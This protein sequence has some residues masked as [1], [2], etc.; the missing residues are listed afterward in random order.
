[1][2]KSP[3]KIQFY[4]K[5]FI[6]IFIIS[7]ILTFI[8]QLTNERLNIL[9]RTE[10]LGFFTTVLMYVFTGM[11][12]GWLQDIYILIEL[13][14][15][16]KCTINIFPQIKDF[17]K[18]NLK[19][20]GNSSLWMFLLFI[21]GLIR[22]IDYSLIGFIVFLNPIYQAGE[23]DPLIYARILVKNHKFKFRL[24]WIFIHL[25]IPII[26]AIILPGS[27]LFFENPIKAISLQVFNSLIYVIWIHILWKFF[28]LPI[29]SNSLQN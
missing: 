25:I 8:E 6:F 10:S 15:T 12:F 17:V 28:R 16:E 7:S 23:I 9:A 18:E 1:M 5:I 21:P 29:L 13:A 14:K 19:A 4:L 24:A 11:I 26:I 3:Q 27:D 20:I 2:L 22:W